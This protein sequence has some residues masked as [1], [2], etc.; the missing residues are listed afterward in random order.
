MTLPAAS[1]SRLIVEVVSSIS[2]PS[3]FPHSQEKSRSP[4]PNQKTGTNRPRR[5][6]ILRS[7]LS[8]TTPVPS[9]SEHSH[10]SLPAMPPV[11]VSEP[12]MS[13]GPSTGMTSSSLSTFTGASA[14]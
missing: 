14:P 3:S 9:G 6:S 1:R 4:L 8:Q 7:L 5:S 2:Q 13:T 10:L 11:P 12:A